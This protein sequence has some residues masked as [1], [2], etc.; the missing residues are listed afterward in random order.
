MKH[1][2]KM[3]LVAGALLV[4]GQALA[5]G[6]HDHGRKKNRRRQKGYLMLPM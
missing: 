3:V 5:H 6:H 1:L 4:S 2:G